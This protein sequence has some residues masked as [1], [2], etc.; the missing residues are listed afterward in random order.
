MHNVHGANAL[1]LY[2][3]ASYW[4]WPYTADKLPNNEREFQLDRD[5]IWYQ[6]WGRY[7]WNC[8]RDRTDEMGY[9]D[10]HET[11]PADR[12]IDWAGLERT[13]ALAVRFLDNVVDASQFP[14]ERIAE[15]VRCV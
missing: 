6:T 11:N 8:H 3:Q 12:G 13:I 7:A 9:W 4:D 14:L 5:W 1:H 10:H 15:Q 2:P